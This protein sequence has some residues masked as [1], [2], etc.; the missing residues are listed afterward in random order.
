[1]KSI[2]FIVTIFLGVSER[3]KKDQIE[4]EV[5]DKKSEYN[6]DKL[7]EKVKVYNRFMRGEMYEFSFVVLNTITFLVTIQTMG[8]TPS[9]LSIL[10]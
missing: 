1:M 4:K 10:N 3:A 6:E 7:K 2:A 8:K 9:V 5:E